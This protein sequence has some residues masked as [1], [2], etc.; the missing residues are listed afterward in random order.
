MKL[1]LGFCFLLFLFVTTTTVSAQTTQ[2]QPIQDTLNFSRLQDGYAMY[3]GKMIHIQNGQVIP[4][5]QNITLKNG[6]KI[7]PNGMVV[8]PGKKEQKLR[9]GY[10]VN[11]NGKIVSLQY[12]MMRYD[13][14]REHSQK[15]LGN[16]DSEIIVTD[17]G[18]LL[19]E[20]PEKRA[21]T[22]EMLNRRLAIIQERN[23]LVQKKAELLNKAKDNKAQQKSTAIKEVDAKLDLLNQEL[24]DL[25][26]KMRDQ[27]EK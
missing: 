4:L 11:L 1:L 18:I 20:T 21:A 14:I 26:Q 3:Q 5:I 19:T 15:T 13:A 16:T 12:D 9:E 17:T 24:K 2:V 6:A 25:D 7:S 22:E 23:S 10:A 27:E 8:L